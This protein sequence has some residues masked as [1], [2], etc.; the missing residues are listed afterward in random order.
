MRILKRVGLILLGLIAL[1]AIAIAVVFTVVN[2]TNGEIVSSGERRRYLLYVPDS[3][4]PAT[5]T[6]L[7]LTFHGFA[8]WPAHQME[9]GHWNDLADED[10]FIVVYPEGTGFPGAGVPTGRPERLANRR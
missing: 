4:D 2:K 3:Y 1:L 7:V 5:P 6:P 10:G 8:E 9:T